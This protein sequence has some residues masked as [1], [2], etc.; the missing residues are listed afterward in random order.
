MKIHNVILIMVLVFLILNFKSVEGNTNIYNT[1]IEGSSLLREEIDTLKRKLIQT[2]EIDNDDIDNILKR[3]VLFAEFIATMK[4]ENNIDIVNCIGDNCNYR[5][6]I[7][8]LF[9]EFAEQYDEIRIEENP[10][11]EDIIENKKQDDF[12]YYKNING[13][14]LRY[15][16]ISKRYL[17]KKYKKCIDDYK[18]LQTS[19]NC[20]DEIEKVRKEEQQK[21]DESSKNINN[22]I[23][24][25]QVKLRNYNSLK[26]Q[27]KQL[28]KDLLNLKRKSITKRWNSKP[29]GVTYTNM[30]PRS[31]TNHNKLKCINNLRKRKKDHDACS[32]LCEKTRGCKHVWQYQKHDRCCFKMKHNK[33][34]G[35]RRG[36]GIIGWYTTH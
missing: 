17:D 22:S 15:E 2:L 8:S 25:L 3:E 7:Q 30:F 32:K 29:S 20:D 21:C 10:E 4:N 35:F 14:P 13:E 18:D 19:Q 23:K 34:K 16:Q 28:T 1:L 26:K 24:L 27:I 6:D 36:R 11:L 5:E 9:L 12:N 33:R 31:E